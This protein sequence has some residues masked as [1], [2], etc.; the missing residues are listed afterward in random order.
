MA[1]QVNIYLFLQENICCAMST[2]NICFCWER[3]KISGFFYWKSSFL[4]ID[5]LISHKNICCGYL[6]ELPRW[7]NFNEYPQH[8]FFVEK[9]EKKIRIFFLLKK[10]VLLIIDFLISLKNICCG[11]SLELPHLGNINGYPQHMFLLRK[12]KKN[13]NFFFFFTEKNLIDYIFPYFS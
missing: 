2:H 1:I 8:R 6:L 9:E 12:K 7:G 3:R 5:F 4:I 10:G 11:Y 13:L